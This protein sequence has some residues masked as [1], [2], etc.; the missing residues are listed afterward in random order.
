MD[1]GLFGLSLSLSLSL[2]FACTGGGGADE[3]SETASS[4][5]ST[6]D[7]SGG[8]AGSAD[9]TGSDGTVG[10]D[11]TD[12]ESSGGQTDTGETGDGDGE[13]ADA[14]DGDGPLE[15][16]VT[17]N[18]GA[19]PQ[20]ARVDGRYRA[21]LLDN[22]GNVTLHY[23]QDQGRLDAKALSFPFEVVVRNI[24]IGTTAD[25]QSAPPPTGD[26]YIF[27]GVQVHTLDFEVRDSAHVVV[28]HRGPTHFTVEGKNTV[29]GVSS[30]NDAGADIVP[31]GRADLR[32]E[33]LGDRSL[34][35]SWQL[36]NPNPGTQADAW[37]LYNGTGGLP[38]PTAA[39]GPTVYVGLIT[40]AF[41]QTGVPFVGTADA[42]EGGSL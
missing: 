40:Y 27:A 32:I 9:A 22:T 39:F 1:R 7:M 23:H 24:G 12:G 3:G 28:G 6:T 4:E 34:R 14:F 26:P 19:L 31:A 37:T 13:F 18:A 41:E 21:D 16:W 2:S 33:G 5:V 29:G 25:A 36:P 10:S 30:V 20:V 8:S 15:G 17:N 38:G 11:G 35:V 42:V